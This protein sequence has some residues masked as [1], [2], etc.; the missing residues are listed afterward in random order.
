MAVD[1]LKQGQ[2][3]RNNDGSVATITHVSGKKVSFILKTFRDQ[4]DVGQT[5]KDNF[6]SRFPI[7]LN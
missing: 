7:K 1:E 4:T 2:K 6:L 5:T 3:Y